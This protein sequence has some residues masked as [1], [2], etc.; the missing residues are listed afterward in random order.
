MFI[1]YGEQNLLNA[2]IKNAINSF[3][4]KNKNYKD[5][6]YIYTQYPI[7]IVGDN[8]LTL[9]VLIVSKKGIA[10]LSTTDDDKTIYRRYV[11]RTCYNINNIAEMLEKNERVIFFLTITELHNYLLTDKNDIL[12]KSDLNLFN[13]E[14]QKANALTLCDSRNIN[15]ENSIG[16][17]IKKRNSA[18]NFYDTT[19][20]NSIYN[21]NI[22]SHVRIRGL[23]GSGKTIILVKKMAYLHYI[24]PE[25][26]LCFTFF[27][28][29]LKQ[30]IQSLFYKFYKEFN[31]ADDNNTNNIMF[32]HCWGSKSDVGFYSNICNQYNLDREELYGDYYRKNTFDEVCSR[33]LN[34]LP[35]NKLG[36]FDFVFVDEAQDFP[37][38]FY[39]LV[40]KSLTSNGKMVYA[41]DELQ[42]LYNP[43]PM[44]TKSQIF[45]D[46]NC[47]D[48]NLGI[49]YRTPKNILITA[50]AIGM[51]I[52]SSLN[53]DGLCNVP[54]DLSIWKAIGYQSVSTIDYGKPV[55]LYRDSSSVDQ[56]SYNSIEIQKFS[57]K[58]EQYSV[59]SKTIYNL[60]T[61]EDV[62]SNDIM[63]IDFDSL[64]VESNYY[65]FKN[66]NV[67]YL[68]RIAAGGKRTYETNLVNKLNAYRFRIN[69]SIPYTTI[70]RAKGNEANIVFIV[71]SNFMSSI[72]SVYRNRLFTAMTRAKMKVYI[73]GCDGLEE[74]INECKL[75]KD[76]N[77]FLRF[78]YPTLDELK[79]QK[80]IAAREDKE[81]KNISKAV[82]LTKDFKGN[83]K[84]MIELILSQTGCNN[85]SELKKYLDYEDKND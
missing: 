29:S 66:Q 65:Q 56:F 79:K 5:D 10:F 77:Y 16:A 51:G 9:K 32:L 78:N 62:Q 75:V 34:K 30:Y 67:S 82:E 19:Q 60:I 71:N 43:N 37:L 41:Y 70:F 59:L 12:D 74:I 39:K 36:I 80:T 61:K 46:E 8:K 24:N 48:I 35:E 69:D 42:N 26:R 31:T 83:R 63:I 54:E 21:I 17:L 64:N 25:L 40:L 73:F 44:P 6:V 20:F 22:D 14:F 3:K 49:C 23:A 15:K 68:N 52:Y 33:L 81:Q 1:N 28:I 27:T 53:N 57:T 11:I 4:E 7:E 84:L 38:S 18:I 2:D 47:E 58:E 72:S 50:H 76:N 45:G 55:I 13:A 85:L